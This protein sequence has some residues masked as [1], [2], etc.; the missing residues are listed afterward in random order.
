MCA[1]IFRARSRL[2]LNTFGFVYLAQCS[3]HG[4]SL[5]AMDA[6][7]EVMRGENES[8]SVGAYVTEQTCS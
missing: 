6:C 2:S 7:A 5:R 4:I 3:C 1:T 8:E